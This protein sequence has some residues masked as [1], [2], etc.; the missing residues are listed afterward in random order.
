MPHCPSIP[1]Q[2]WSQLVLGKWPSAKI[3]YSFS[4]PN[5]ALQAFRSKHR[6][7]AQGLLEKLPEDLINSMRHHFHK[8][9]MAS[10]GAFEFEEVEAL[11]PEHNG[12]SVSFCSQLPSRG[13][14]AYTEYVHEAGE[15]WHSHIC[16]PTYLTNNHLPFHE[17]IKSHEIGH[18]LGLDHLH[19]SA[20][21]KQALK[22]TA[23]GQACSVMPYKDEITSKLSS[24]PELSHPIEPGPLDKQMLAH[25][26]GQEPL[27]K[28]MIKISRLRAV[29]REYPVESVKHWLWLSTLALALHQGCYHLSQHWL[30]HQP[31]SQRYA[32]ILSNII[33]D[34]CV[35]TLLSCQ[36]ELTHAALLTVSIGLFSRGLQR[37]SDSSQQTTASPQPLSLFC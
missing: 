29:A 23:Q 1:S 37:F 26:Y 9:Q 15:L 12:I 13:Q 3:S 22:D 10:Q 27:P 24:L 4:L 16:L 11:S 35:L 20:S 2:D 6:L 18:A 17:Y 25:L 19:N 32:P 36:L 34:L 30:R 31:Q 5:T 33:A 8:W 28:P 7:T 21:L 14:E